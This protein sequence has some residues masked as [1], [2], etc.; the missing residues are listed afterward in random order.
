MYAVIER[1]RERQP[2][3]VQVTWRGRSDAYML[4]S[5]D[6]VA[7]FDCSDPHL[8]VHGPG[9]WAFSDS[10]YW[11]EVPTSAF[12]TT[13]G[14]RVFQT[15]SPAEKRWKRWTR[16]RKIKLYVMDLW[17]VDEIEDLMYVALVIA[18]QLSDQAAPLASFPNMMLMPRSA[19]K[20]S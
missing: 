12:A 10:T 8:D 19:S 1:L 3:A 2:V 20:H 18:A 15:A 6:G 13:P 11:A 5:N 7:N 4:F 9:L 17:T 16:E 14:V